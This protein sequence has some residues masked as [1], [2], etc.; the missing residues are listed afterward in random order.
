MWS[1]RSRSLTVS[2]CSGCRRRRVAP[3]KGTKRSKCSA[4]ESTAWGPRRPLPKRDSRGPKA[5]ASQRGRPGA[6]A[7]P[8]LAGG[9][10]SK[11]TNNTSFI[12]T[13]LHLVLEKWGPWG[14]GGLPEKPRRPFHIPLPSPSTTALAAPP[15][16]TPLVLFA[17]P[18]EALDAGWRR[19]CGPRLVR[20]WQGVRRRRR[21]SSGSWPV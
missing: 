2:A 1:R 16:L 5:V 8:R 7:S 4:Q 12:L 10:L 20:V 19:A 11:N 14:A 18:R 6:A 9:K 21:A 15:R 13:V 3:R 17:S